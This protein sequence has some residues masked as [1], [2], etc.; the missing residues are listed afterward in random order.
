[1]SKIESRREFLKKTTMLI[2]GAAVLGGASMLAGCGAE[3]AAAPA[4][5]TAEPAPAA[6]AAPA[7]PEAPAHPFAYKEIDPAACEE[8]AY[9]A[10]FDDIGGCC[11]GTAHGML[12]ELR[13]KV[14][15]P[16]TQI[17]DAMFANGAGGYGQQSLCGSLGG[18]IAV[19]GMVCEPK[20]AKK[21][22]AEL[23]DWYKNA[24]L[25]QY[26]PEAEFE[27]YTVCSSVN[28]K[29]S[30]GLFM[31]ENGIKEMSELPRKQ[32]CAGVCADTARKA[33]ELLNVEFGFAEPAPAESAPAEELAANEYIGVGHNGFGGDVKV[34]VTM[35]G[36]KIKTIDVLESKETL[37]QEINT[38]IG[39][40]VEKNSAEVDAVSGATM[41]SNAIM[42]AVA[43]AL[44]Q[45]SK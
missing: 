41:S 28:C 37:T 45:I 2:G 12:E 42:E 43:D 8:T 36:D 1:M 25:P 26:H 29:D 14:G 27:K 3:P 13:K 22:T 33:A 17:P 18:A 24:A 4:D 20:T 21:V 32:R 15:Y 23:C 9:K 5:P 34:K 16:F 11:Y 35:D 39:N 31:K 38:L 19:I 10:F 30:V 6:P 7:E 44:S 40:I